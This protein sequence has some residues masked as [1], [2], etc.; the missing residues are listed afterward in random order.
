[1]PGLGEELENSR[2]V[3]RSV[4]AVARRHE[5]GHRA[6]LFGHRADGGS[7]GD[8]AHAFTFRGGSRDGAGGTGGDAGTV[9]KTLSARILP[10]WRRPVPVFEGDIQRDEPAQ[11]GQGQR[12]QHGEPHRA[13]RDGVAIPD[14]QGIGQHRQ[15]GDDQYKGQEVIHGILA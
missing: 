8:S 1:M 12:E 9:R 10:F 7:H 11:P 13:G 4:H 15:P 3:H 5:R 14:Q 6:G 2:T